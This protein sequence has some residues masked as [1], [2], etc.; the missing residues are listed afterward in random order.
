MTARPR[1]NLGGLFDGSRP[2]DRPSSM[3]G[4]LGPASATTSVAERSQARRPGHSWWMDP[5]RAVE[6][7]FGVLQAALDANRE[8]ALA[9]ANLPTP[10]ALPAVVPWKS[11]HESS[12]PHEDVENPG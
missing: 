5:I 10:F 12:S 6:L 11:V 4:K 8:F 7:S 9:L 3:A 1:P 2:S